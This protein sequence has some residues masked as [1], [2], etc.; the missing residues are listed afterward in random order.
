MPTL[1][2]THPRIADLG[3]PRIVTIGGGAGGLE[4]H[5]E[6][7][8][9]KIRDIR[10]VYSPSSLLSLLYLAPA[11]NTIASSFNKYYDKQKRFLHHLVE[12]TPRLIQDIA[13]KA[14]CNL[15]KYLRQTGVN[16]YLIGNV[17][18]GKTQTNAPG[19]VL[20]FHPSNNSLVWKFTL[21]PPVT[22]FL[23]ILFVRA[24]LTSYFPYNKSNRLII[25]R[26]KGCAL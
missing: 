22:Y 1:I 20:N 17:I 13:D 23:T 6:R 5:S 24:G 3:K 10:V 16:V 21:V 2:T 15:W 25:A 7:K 19:K 18:S 14:L 26:L 12:A 8:V 9:S 4:A 11:S